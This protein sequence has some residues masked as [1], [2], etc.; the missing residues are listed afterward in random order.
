MNLKKG[1]VMR[2]TE[3]A[4]AR[5]AAEKLY[6]WNLVLDGKHVGEPKITFTGALPKSCAD[7]LLRLAQKWFKEGKMK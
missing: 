2:L 4:K 6:L 5:A 3:T 1:C 7:E